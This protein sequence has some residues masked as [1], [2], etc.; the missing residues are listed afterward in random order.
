M[1][2]K[3]IPRRAAQLIDQLQNC[4]DIAMNFLVAS[5]CKCAFAA[6]VKS[7][8]ELIH[9]G[10]KSGISTKPNHTKERN[11]CLEVFASSFSTM[12]KKSTMIF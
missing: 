5:Y 8:E 7:K 3:H 12:P 6:Y 2:D 11:L 10:Q 4:E 9:Y 1:F